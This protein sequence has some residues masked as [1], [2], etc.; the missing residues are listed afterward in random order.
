MCR[1]DYCPYPL[2][3]KPSCQKCSAQVKTHPPQATQK[4][5][6]EKYRNMLVRCPHRGYLIKKDYCDTLYRNGRCRKCSNR[7]VV[8]TVATD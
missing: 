2:D 6:L 5:Q 3:N 1:Y 8:V 7:H 4:F